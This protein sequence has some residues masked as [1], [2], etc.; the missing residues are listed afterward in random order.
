M[1]KVAL[2]EPS[3]DSIVSRRPGN[4]EPPSPSNDSIDLSQLSHTLRSKK[5]LIFGAGLFVFGAVMALTLMSRMTFCTS[6]RL[7]L[8]ELDDRG[9]GATADI[10]LT[11]S[12][13]GDVGS[14]VEILKSRSLV[15]QAI[16]RSGL[17]ATVQPAGGRAPRMWRWLLSGRDPKLLDV[18]VKQVRVLHAKLPEAERSKQTFQLRFLSNAEYELWS[19]GKRLGQGKIHEALKTSRVTLTV[20]PGDQRRPAAGA[21]YDVQV[22][23]LDDVYSAALDGLT[24]TTPKSPAGTTPVKVVLLEFGDRSPLL[25]AAFLRELM[26]AYLDERQ[27]WKTEDATA[28]ESFVTSRLRTMRESLDNSEQKLADYRSNTRV[29]VLDDEAKAMI[30]QMGKYE[31]QRVAARLEIAA[32]A[33][34]KRALK[35]RNTPIEAYLFGEA[36]DSVLQGMASS[37]S[38]ARQKLTDLESR[39][40][41]SAPDVQEQQAQVNAQLESIRNYVSNRLGRAQ[42]NLG[43]FNRIIA[44]FEEK[45]K[46]VPG[47]ELGLAQLSRESEVYSRM[48]SQLL[49]RQQQAAIVKASTVSKNRILDMPQVVYREDSPKLLFRMTS[50]LLGLLLGA[51]VVV[52]RQV[53]ASTLQTESDVR[54]STQHLPIFGRVPWHARA[55]GKGPFEVRNMDSTSAYA[56]SI[57]SVRTNLYQIR[58]NGSGQVVMITSPTPGD[59]KTTCTMALAAMLAADGKWVLVIDADVRKPSHHEL[60]RE[61]I[62]PG[63]SEALRGR[64]DWKQAVRPITV[65]KGEFYSLTVGRHGSPELISQERFGQLLVEARSR[66]DFVLLDAPSYPLLSDAFLLASQADTVLTVVRLGA[67]SRRLTAEHTSELKRVAGHYG[68]IVND[69]AGGGV[70]GEGVTNPRNSNER[71]PVLVKLDS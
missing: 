2:R 1:W 3:D 51:I 40:N 33:D 6:G 21:E 49:E 24:V 71:V 8:G 5:R 60:L 31:E 38:E 11:G 29:V 18:G 48:Y 37:L 46:S 63:L 12:A 4:P 32:L 64:A 19:D 67:T 53:F 15:T 41:A 43:T 36:K 22:Q 45:L 54:A 59:G 28:A 69:S 57:R 61:D 26:A 39:F 35:Q 25:A 30:E 65:R 17:N 52:A 9:R 13:Q 44:Q 27:N 50:L 68:V 56:E 34:V 70:Y 20:E 14:E 62:Q 42:D 66:Y 7:Y 23:P 58:L 10:D 55:G 16:L 47:A